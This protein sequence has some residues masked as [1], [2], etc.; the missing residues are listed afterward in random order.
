MHQLERRVLELIGEDPDNPDVFSD[1]TPIRDALNDGIQEVVMV[2]GSN[3]RQYFVPLR[4]NQQFYRL[5]LNYG[6]VGWITDVWAINR[7]RRL[8][9]TGI[10]RLTRHDPRWMIASSEPRSY[11]QIGSEVLALYPKPSGTTDTLEVSLVEIPTDYA[12]DQAKIRLKKD[13]EYG[14]VHYAV[15]EYWASRGDAREALKHFNEYLDVMGLREEF[16][17]S[18]YATTRFRTL[19]EPWPRETA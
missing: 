3:K 5:T 19:K 4:A 15:S 18:P 12:D 7:K 6:Y 10:M 2:T 17:Q 11:L 9:Q 13:F 14:V 8:E 16:D 1:I